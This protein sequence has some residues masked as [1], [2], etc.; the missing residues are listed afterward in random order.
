MNINEAKIIID[1]QLEKVIYADTGGV[2][3]NLHP[4]RVIQSMKSIIGMDVDNPSEKLIRWGEKYSNNIDTLAKDYFKYPI[5][6]PKE[7]IVLS[8]LGKYILSGDQPKSIRELQDLCSVSD[9]NQIF[10]YLIEFSS[11]HHKRALSLIWSAYRIN[12]FM[13]N[14]FS[15]QLL[16]LSVKS[17][18]KNQFSSNGII[19]KVDNFSVIEAI[20]STPLTRSF[21]I[22]ENLPNHNLKDILFNS[23]IPFSSEV[24]ILAKGR[25]AILD[26]LNDLEFEKITKELI[27]FLDACRAILKKTNDYDNEIANIIDQVVGGCLHVKENW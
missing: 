26:Y 21:R 17:L 4:I 24:D 18:L 6:K 19:S 15:Y 20:S 16:L 23:D 11:V 5:N 2:L 8:D 7:T 25:Y 1:K 3:D 9:G 12:I 22:N 10:E 14:K 13:K 27:L